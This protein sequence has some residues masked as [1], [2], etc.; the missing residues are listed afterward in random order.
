LCEQ[1]FEIQDNIE[2]FFFVKLSTSA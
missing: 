1:E 2:Y